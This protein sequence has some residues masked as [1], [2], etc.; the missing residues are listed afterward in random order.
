MTK[1][2]RTNKHKHQRQPKLTKAAIARQDVDPVQYVM[3]A[4]N[5]DHALAQLKA[6][7]ADFMKQFNRPI[8]QVVV[9]LT[10]N[11]EEIVQENDRVLKTV[12]QSKQLF[13]QFHRN[14]QSLGL[15]EHVNIMYQFM[16]CSDSCFVVGAIYLDR[17]V[18][19]CRYRPIISSNSIHNLFT[20][21][22]ALAAKLL[23]DTHN[24][25]AFYAEIAG[26]PVAYMNRLEVELLWLLDFDIWV[27]EVD[28]ERCTAMLE[29]M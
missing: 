5:S 3:F 23:D 1:L 14:P 22:V 4:D 26:L 24:N 28:Y 27:W 11:L 19:R 2:G 16:K 13:T 17:V 6:P 12:P 18:R 10:Q 21:C 15:R 7:P 29:A 9:A 8:P 20:S 25:N